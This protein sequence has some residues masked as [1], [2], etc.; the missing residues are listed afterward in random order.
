MQGL[1]RRAWWYLVGLS[2]LI[3]LFGAGDV[4]GGVSVDPGIDAAA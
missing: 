1:R 2:V 3:A 4:I